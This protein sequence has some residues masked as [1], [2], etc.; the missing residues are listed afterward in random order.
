MS[1]SRRSSHPCVQAPTPMPI[2]GFIPCELSVMPAAA[3]G[4]N[5][6]AGH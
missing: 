3:P 1:R 4:A 2:C 5:L 6:P